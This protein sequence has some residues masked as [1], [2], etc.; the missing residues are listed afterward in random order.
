VTAI[1]YEVRGEVDESHGWVV[2]VASLLCALHLA[3]CPL[4]VLFSVTGAHLSEHLPSSHCILRRIQRGACSDVGFGTWRAQA[5]ECRGAWRL[6][7][8]PV[9]PGAVVFGSSGSD[10]GTAPG[11]FGGA[12]ERDRREKEKEGR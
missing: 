10:S 2:L 6:T 7:L 4:P 8:G 9:R 5:R 3:S 11:H 12:W 1:G